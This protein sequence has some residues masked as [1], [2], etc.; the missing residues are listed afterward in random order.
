MFTFSFEI[1]MFSLQQ[2]HAFL[3]SKG[4][5]PSQFRV[6]NL[7]PRQRIAPKDD[8]ISQLSP[9][10]GLTLVVE[11]LYEDDSADETAKEKWKFMNCKEKKRAVRYV[12][13][14]ALPLRFTSSSISIHCMAHA[15]KFVINTEILRNDLT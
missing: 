4:Y 7:F 9:G 15:S 3:E 1:R 8:P 13:N 5:P 2:L 6:Y 12:H 11:E 14:N 10:R